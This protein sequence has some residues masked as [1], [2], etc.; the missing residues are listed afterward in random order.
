MKALKD[1]SGVKLWNKAKKLIPGGNQLLS[2]RSE[3]FLPDQWPSYYR[4]AKGVEVWDMDDNHYWDMSIMGIGTAILGYANE[5]VNR[6]VEQAISAG[7]MCTLNCHEEVELAEKLV[8]LHPWAEMARFARNG[9]EAC[10]IAVR[11]GRAFSQKSRVAF[12]G[13]HG[14]HDWYLAAN[15]KDPN[16]LNTHLLKGLEATGVPMELAGT[17]VPFSYGERDEFRKLVQ[18]HGKDLGVIIMEVGRQK[19][20]DKEFLQEVRATASKIG[21][22][23]IF[24]EVTSGFRYRAGGMHVLYG[25]N[26]DIVVLGKA[27]GN[28]FPISAVV[29]KRAVMEAAQVSFISSTYWTER[30]GLVAALAVIKE[31]ETKPVAEHLLKLGEYLT[32]HLTKIFKEFNLNLEVVGLAPIPIMAIKEKEPLLIKSVFTQEMLKREFLAGNVVYL[33]LAHTRELLDRYL[34]QAREVFRDI[35]S[36]RQQ[37][38]LEKMLEGPV[39]HSGFQRLA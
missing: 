2:K 21:A 1:N 16:Q 8:Q 33:S 24:D 14:W 30:I 4:K 39:C 3:M 18:Q 22:V 11:I 38:C 31:F 5:E 15:L 29:G 10:T 27:M 17:A 7:S 26:P 13:Y 37:G 28:G 36:A 9:G 6:A 32:S 34:E 19:K 25:V 23:L 20:I 35:V 12:C